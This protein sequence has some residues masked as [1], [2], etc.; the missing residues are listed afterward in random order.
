MIQKGLNV[1]YCPVCGSTN[2]QVKAWVDAN[3][4]KFC[5]DIDSSVD[6]ED[7][8]CENCDD[9]NGLVTLKELWERFS[10]VPVD[11]NDEIE[12]DFICF[13]VGT[14]KFDV[15]HWFDER[16]PNNLHDDLLFPKSE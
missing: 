15:W 9:H 3:T 4:D 14:S 16:C 6:I 5:S 12:E 10:E 7:T 1:F 2:V 11:N 8:W 13:S